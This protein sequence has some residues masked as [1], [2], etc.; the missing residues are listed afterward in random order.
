MN[1]NYKVSEMIKF[2]SIV[3]VIFVAIMAPWWIRNY[4]V[5]D[6]VIL[7][8]YATGN[9]M[10]QG[11]YINYD[12]SVKDTTDIEYGIDH[13]K[14]PYHYRDEFKN[15]ETEVA[16]SKERFWKVLKN[17]PLRYIGWYTIGK[18]AHNWMK[19]FYW[20]EIY[21]ISLNTVL[22]YHWILLIS[23]IMGFIFYL[24]K[25]GRNLNFLFISMIILY[26][27]CIYLPFYA[28]SR[29][30]YP[31]T[32]LMIILSAYGIYTVYELIRY[33]YFDKNNM[34]I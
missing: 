30:M 29:Y 4:V 24:Y 28:F 33:G 17:E 7:F 25:R 9:P 13:D 5:F 12:Q 16:L 11:T 1:K 32:S 15:N 34:G 23:A 8:T 14:F 27:N 18:T 2:A 21:N 20:V 31:V 26:F 19:P 22:I 10:L 6:K 3:I